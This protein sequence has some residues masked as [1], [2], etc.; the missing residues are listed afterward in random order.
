MQVQPGRPVLSGRSTCASPQKKKKG[1]SHTRPHSKAHGRHPESGSQGRINRGQAAIHVARQECKLGTA[2]SQRGHN[3]LA[4]NE[5]YLYAARERPKKG[6]VGDKNKQR[7]QQQ[8]STS[9][10]SPRKHNS[11][12]RCKRQAACTA[13]STSSPAQQPTH[14]SQ[15][16]VQSPTQKPAASPCAVHEMWSRGLIGRGEGHGRLSHV[17]SGHCSA[18]AICHKL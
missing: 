17:T 15:T 10:N 13:K 1:V 5:Q 2:A 9:N 3:T 11:T 7:G 6:R 4:R 16:R 18:W 8:A 14:F 12:E